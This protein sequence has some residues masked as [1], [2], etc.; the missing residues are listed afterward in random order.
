MKKE[1]IKDTKAK[2]YDYKG[3]IFIKYK[4]EYRYKIEQV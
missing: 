3:T 2:T 1:F 4:F